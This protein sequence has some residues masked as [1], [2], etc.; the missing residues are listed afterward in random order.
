MA[1]YPEE[2][3][4][5]KRLAKEWYDRNKVLKQ[6]V[7]RRQWAELLSHSNSVDSEPGEEEKENRVTTMANPEADDQWNTKENPEGEKK[8]EEPKPEDFQSED[9]LN[10]QNEIEMLID[11]ESRHQESV[12]ESS[13]Q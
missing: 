6:E 5:V 4:I 2:G 11:E 9:R 10:N 8:E 7:V 1:K 3:K 13:V 12:Q